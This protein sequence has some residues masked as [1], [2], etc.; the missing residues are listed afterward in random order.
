MIEHHTAL[1][2]FPSG[3]WGWKWTGDPDRAPG[4]EQPA[5]WNYPILPYLEQQA[6]FDLGADG[7]PDNITTQQRDGAWERDQ[8]PPPLFNCPTRR[9]QQIYP[10]PKNMTYH[11]GKAINT[12]GIID[13]AAN[14]GDTSPIWAEGPASISAVATHDFSA[15]LANTGISFTRSQINR[16][17]IR[18][19]AS[20]TYMIGEKSLMPTNYADGQ[21]TADDFGMYEGCAHD[22]YRWCYAACAPRRD[23]LGE[24]NYSCFGSAHPA[25]TV[26]MMC[27]G[28]IL[29]I[30]HG[31]DATIHALLGNR[32]DE[33]PVDVSKL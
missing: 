15:S 12:A 10:R 9:R 17:N 31:V 22:T 33:K 11:N 27:D 32:K 20:N 1:G 13:Y 16:G 30:R 25:G 8:T 29:V 24:D 3:G 7:E 21:N 5:G 4:A 28:S 18:D 19:G 2:F 6:L 26:M 23:R 14:A